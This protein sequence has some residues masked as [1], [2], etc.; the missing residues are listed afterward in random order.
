[1]DD[2]TIKKIDDLNTEISLSENK[3]EKA[4]EEIKLLKEKKLKME[5]PDLIKEENEDLKL[6]HELCIEDIKAYNEKIIKLKEMLTKKEEKL[7]KLREENINLKKDTNIK[8]EEPEP[9]KNL[10]FDFKELFKSIGLKSVEMT[11]NDV[12]ENNTVKDEENIKMINK[13]KVEEKQKEFEKI[14]DEL[15]NKA[16]QINS[17]VNKQKEIINEHKKYLNEINSYLSKFREKLNISIN[18]KILNNN[19]S[20]IKEIKTL[21]DKNSVI[22]LELDNIIKENKD[23]SGQSIENLLINIQN[24]I[25]DLNLNDNKNEANFENKCEEINKKINSIKDI[26]NNFEINKNKFDKKNINVEKGIKELKN[27]HNQLIE[28]EKKNI[29]NNKKN[30]DTKNKN[31]NI[32]NN[33]NNNNANKRKKIIEQSFLYNVKN[34]NK[35]LD[36]YKTVNLFK[37][38]ENELDNNIE[39]S[40]LKKKNYHEICYIYDEYDTHDIYYT[41]KAV[42]LPDN[43]CFLESNLLLDND[44]EIEILEFTLDDIPSN[45]SKENSN[46]IT[47]N[48]NLYNLDSIKVHIIYKEKKDLSNKLHF[49][50]YYGLNSNFAGINTKYSL[51]LKCNY[52]I[53]D[54]DEFF[55]IRNIN[56]QEEVEYIWGGVIPNNGKRVKIT[57]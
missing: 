11:D 43:E 17:I 15:K 33:N 1:M 50:K 9:L 13:E 32:N 22:L 51:I 56:N 41:L 40:E 53:I 25:N 55:L 46:Y 28:Q 29:I 36:L 34:A 7:S 48:I 39:F 21:V 3:L 52:D 6:T 54:F 26:F 12:I 35:K 19:K 44:D 38:D 49:W 4:E 5:N 10:I 47:F 24:D 42:G 45:Y 2:Q 57:F 31:K 30:T 20:K 8:K 23:N 14:L 27:E 16:N 37:N 18:N